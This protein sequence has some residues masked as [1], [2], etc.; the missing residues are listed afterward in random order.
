MNLLRLSALLVGCFTLIAVTAIAVAD[1]KAVDKDRI[2]GK[3]QHERQ[4]GRQ[5]K[6]TIVIQFTKDGKFKVSI[7][8]QGLLR[9]G[10]TGTQT[11]TLEGTYKIEGDKLAIVQKQGEK[12]SKKSVTI[13]SLTDKKLVTVD[14]K[15]KEDEFEKK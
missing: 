8:I 13:K 10:K 5:T 2:V 9:G 15:G 6:E 7:T 12:E 1:D 11:E 3:W 4:A 14:A